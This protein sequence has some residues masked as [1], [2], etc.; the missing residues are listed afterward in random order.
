MRTIS[1]CL[2]SAVITLALP[3]CAVP[4]DA[5]GPRRAP[6]VAEAVPAESVDVSGDAAGPLEPPRDGSAP[7]TSP[8]EAL[9]ASIDDPVLRELLVE[10]LERNAEVREARAM[11]MAASALVQRR[12]KRVILCRPAVEAGE[13]LG[14]LPGDLVEKVNPYLRPLYDALNDMLDFDKVEQLRERATV[15]RVP[16]EDVLVDR[17]LFQI[18]RIALHAPVIR[19]G[20]HSLWSERCEPH[21]EQKTCQAPHHERS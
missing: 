2:V 4:R 17:D 12:I 19:S 3:A 18:E 9:V 8:S 11:A 21:D 16:H 10:V 7:S 15:V 14:F 5:I 20:V 6:G 13:K 1:R